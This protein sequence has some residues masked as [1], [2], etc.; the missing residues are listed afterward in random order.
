[1]VTARPFRTPP[2]FISK[3]LAKRLLALGRCVQEQIA[4]HA[5]LVD[6]I[7]VAVPCLGFVDVALVDE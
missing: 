3:T 5:V 1:M 6:H 2:E 4:N 7:P